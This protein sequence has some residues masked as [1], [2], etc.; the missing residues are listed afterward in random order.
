M[1]V[2]G[3][4]SCAVAGFSLCVELSDCIGKDI[5]SCRTSSFGKYNYRDV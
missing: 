1:D 2:A 4:V 5:V 3:S